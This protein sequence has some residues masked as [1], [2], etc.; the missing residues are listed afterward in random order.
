MIS[1]SA[2]DLRRYPESSAAYL[3]DGLPPNSANGASGPIC[4]VPQAIV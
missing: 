4:A 1:S 2:G 3:L